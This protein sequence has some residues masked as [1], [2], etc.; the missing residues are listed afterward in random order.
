MSNIAK[1]LFAINGVILLAI[2]SPDVQALVAGHP[3]SAIAFTIISNIS[4]L[5]ADYAKKA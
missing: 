5:I 1:I 3:K 2:A 4:H